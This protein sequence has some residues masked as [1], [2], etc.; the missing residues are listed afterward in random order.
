VWGSVNY[1]SIQVAHLAGI[2]SGIHQDYC[3]GTKC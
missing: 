3:D 1:C 2:Y